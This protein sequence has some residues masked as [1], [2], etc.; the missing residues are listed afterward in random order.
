MDL[1][2]DVIRARYTEMQC[3]TFR[4]F[5]G[6]IIFVAWA[7]ED[8]TMPRLFPAESYELFSVKIFFIMFPKLC[9]NLF[10]QVY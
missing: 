2:E 10:N 6:K 4:V 8:I 1:L 9:H 5:N 3:W 7:F